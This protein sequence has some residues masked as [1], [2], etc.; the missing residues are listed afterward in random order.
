MSG[1]MENI[2]PHLAEKQFRTVEKRLVELLTSAG[3]L[4]GRSR[5]FSTVTAYTY[6]HQEV[7]QKLLRKLTGYSLGTISTALQTLEK[8]GV[9]HKHFDPSTREYHYE[10]DG[11]ISQTLFRSLRDI[12]RYLSQIKEFFRGI[13]AKLSQPEL[14][15]KKGYENI[16]QF[17]NELN[18]LIPAYEQVFQRF[19]TFVS[20]VNPKQEV[21]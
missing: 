16:L 9:V 18:G 17:I 19:Q 20:D 12:Q 6:I 14:F 15:K 21:Q 1:Q 4:K 13:E 10:L 3:Y 8:Q 5:K 2:K 11:T 7:T